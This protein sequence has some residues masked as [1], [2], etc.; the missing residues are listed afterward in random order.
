MDHLIMG[1]KL[2]VPKVI[3]EVRSIKYTPIYNTV[4]VDIT[5]NPHLITAS[6]ILRFTHTKDVVSFTLLRGQAEVMERVIKNESK[7]IG[8]KIS[9]TNLPKGLTIGAILREEKVFI[10]K[11]DTHLQED[12]HLVIFSKPDVCSNLDRCFID[13]FT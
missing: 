11:S 5:I 10:P 6:Q 1:N 8:K 12:D 4:G 3:S 2:G 7:V 9:E 13:S